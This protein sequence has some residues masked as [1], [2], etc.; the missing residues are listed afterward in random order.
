MGLSPEKGIFVVGGVVIKGWQSSHDG[1][2]L[3]EP[4]DVQ[5]RGYW[6][7]Y[8]QWGTG[9]RGLGGQMG[10]VDYGGSNIYGKLVR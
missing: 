3:N 6:P 4:V 2:W 1:Y 5:A 10:V 9:I 7:D 8:M